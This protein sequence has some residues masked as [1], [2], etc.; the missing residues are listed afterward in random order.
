MF[1]IKREVKEE[2][3]PLD[4]DEI[5]KLQDEID[6]LYNKLDNILTMYRENTLLI[7]IP[8]PSY[9][10]EYLDKTYASIIKNNGKILKTKDVCEIEWYD[11]Y[12]NKKI[13]K[14]TENKNMK[15]KETLQNGDLVIWYEKQTKEKDSFWTLR[16]EA[17]KWVERIYHKQEIENIIVPQDLEHVKDIIATIKYL[18][19]KRYNLF[20]K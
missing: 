10:H 15:R 3:K 20:G 14:I 16:I 8:T 17:G 7:G 12:G 19:E 11:D 18:K 5:N 6:I 1:L 9:I 2:T 4:V 13:A